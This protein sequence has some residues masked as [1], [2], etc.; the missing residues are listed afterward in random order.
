MRKDMGTSIDG[1][2]SQIP[3]LKYKDDGEPRPGVPPCDC[4]FAIHRATHICDYKNHA[5]KTP[6]HVDIKNR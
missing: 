3:L 2:P 1:H 5:M 4:Q 6:V